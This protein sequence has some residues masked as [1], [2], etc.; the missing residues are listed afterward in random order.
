MFVNSDVSYT[1]I[2][3]DIDLKI[4]RVKHRYQLTVIVHFS[5]T[6]LSWHLYTAISRTV[7]GKKCARDN[8]ER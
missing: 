4:L 7:V 3:G 5:A 2:N 6:I 8:P 1:H